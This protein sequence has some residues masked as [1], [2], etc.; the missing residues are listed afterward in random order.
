[1]L[2]NIVVAVGIFYN[3]GA[4]RLD[5][6]LFFLILKHENHDNGM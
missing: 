5:I 3:I 2:S 1:M 6:H 4:P